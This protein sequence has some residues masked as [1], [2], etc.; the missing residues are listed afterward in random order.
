MCCAKQLP[1]AATRSSRESVNGVA[2][3][4][5]TSEAC[6]SATDC[7]QNAESGSD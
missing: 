4:G 5:S 7:R 6:V 2:T 3:T 1:A